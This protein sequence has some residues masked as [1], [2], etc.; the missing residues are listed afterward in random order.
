MVNAHDVAAWIINWFT[1]NADENDLTQLKLQ[2]LL[3]YA[4]G[5]HLALTGERLFEDAVVAMPHGP[6]VSNVYRDYSSQRTGVYTITEPI[7]GDPTK[8]TQPMSEVL[9][10]VMT[11]MGQFSAWR[12]R[13]MTHSE[14]P[15]SETG[16][17]RE[18]TPESLVAHFK[19]Q[20]EED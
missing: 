5:Y 10:E 4:Q 16:M 17:G 15:W 9:S 13:D 7:E 14:T 11:V 3:Y 18:I 12:L 8:L 19:E 2:K 1:N 6:V 20:V